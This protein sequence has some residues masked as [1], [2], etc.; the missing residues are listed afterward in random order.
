MNI[1]EKT[2]FLL[3]DDFVCI[4][5]MLRENLRSLGMKG[6][7]FDAENIADA[8]KI[9]EDQHGS[10]TSVEFVFSDWQM[11]GGT[12]LDF[13]EKV[14]A[15]SRFTALPFIMVTTQNEQDMVLQA[16]TAGVSN[17]LVKPWNIK[18]LSEKMESVWQKHHKK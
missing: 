8:F 18:G 16:V 17:Y 3:V 5:K 15:D 14:R 12:G 2:T 4:R 13:L 7:I 9:L 6:E 10:P 11:P 1:P